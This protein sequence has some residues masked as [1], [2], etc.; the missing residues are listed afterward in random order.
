MRGVRPISTTSARSVPTSTAAQLSPEE[1]GDVVPTD[2][3]PSRGPVEQHEH[4][5]ISAFDLFSIGGTPSFFCT[6]MA[7]R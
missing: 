6:V 7:A 4:A 5:V 1:D 3:E 2:E